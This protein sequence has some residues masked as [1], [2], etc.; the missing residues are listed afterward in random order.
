MAFSSLLQT[1]GFY[2]RG[3][4]DRLQG[5]EALTR[6]ANYTI[7]YQNSLTALAGGGQ[8]G[9][10]PL[11][12]GFNEVD[13]VATNNDSVMLP[14]A[15][16]GSSVDIYNAGANTLAIYANVAQSNGSSADQMIAKSTNAKTGAAASITIASGHSTVFVCTTLGLFKQLYD[17]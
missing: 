10:T 14:A 17:V 8:A 6:L 13:T 12:T 9:A 11:A 5:D 1:L 2:N 15:I 16:P 4:G 3:G 7:G